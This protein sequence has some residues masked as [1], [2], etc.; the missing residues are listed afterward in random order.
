[1]VKALLIVNRSLGRGEGPNMQMAPQSTSRLGKAVVFFCRPLV[2]RRG[3]MIV[4]RG[5]I[6]VE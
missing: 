5:L 6:I 3:F 2:D 1:M 4:G